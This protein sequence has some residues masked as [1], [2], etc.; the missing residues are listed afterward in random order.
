MYNVFPYGR[1]GFS[2]KGIEVYF[3]ISSNL[4][5]AFYCPSIYLQLKESFSSLHPRPSS[6]GFLVKRS[7]KW[8]KTLQSVSINKSIVQYLNELQI[9]SSSR[10]IYSQINDFELV[11]NCLDKKS[12]NKRGHI[13]KT[14]G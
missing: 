12:R 11:V 10:F 14:L 1:E 8:H 2:E 4:C 13:K 9:R 5:V 3:P 7:F 6:Q